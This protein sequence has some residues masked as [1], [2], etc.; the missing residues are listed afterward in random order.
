MGS[1]WFG[2]WQKFET[3]VRIG[4]NCVHVVLFHS[5]LSSIQIDSN[6]KQVLAHNQAHCS[7][8][9]QIRPF[10]GF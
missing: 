10:Y 3:P 9:N 5:V 8:A 6:R 4:A 7:L 2:K 1:V